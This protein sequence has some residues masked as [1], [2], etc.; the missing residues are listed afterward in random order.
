MSE[1]PPPD[2]TGKQRRH[3]RAL[4]HA[5]K[6]VL[7]LGKQGF[8][9]ELPAQLEEVLLAREL[10]KVK[11]LQNCPLSADECGAELR[12]VSG[13]HIAQRVGRTLLLY[14]PHPE[15]PSIVLPAGRET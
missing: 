13:A 6:P 10:I 2:L 5:L 3:L 14:R 9:P 7:T 8:G 1:A 4:G 15:Q 12:R 11:V